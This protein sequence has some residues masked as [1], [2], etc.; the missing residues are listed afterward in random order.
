MKYV[1]IRGYTLIY[2]VIRG[3]V[4]RDTYRTTERE[5]E[6]R[7]MQC[8]CVCVC[9]CA[10]YLRM[11]GRRHILDTYVYTSLLWIY[12]D[13]RGYKWIN[14]YNRG[15]TLIYVDIRGYARICVDMCGYT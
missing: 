6:V 9:V 4:Q 1:E 5:E 10:A 13:M 7:S 12:E 11:C 14:V 15:Y 8:V 3:Y 2:M